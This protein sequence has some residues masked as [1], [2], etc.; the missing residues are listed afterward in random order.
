MFISVNWED[1]APV[2]RRDNAGMLNWSGPAGCISNLPSI[3]VHMRHCL[4][5]DTTYNDTTYDGTF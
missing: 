4:G 3:A 1:G 2:N 5:G